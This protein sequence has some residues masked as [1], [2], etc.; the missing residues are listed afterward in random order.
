[1]VLVLE[2]Q[3]RQEDRATGRRLLDGE[4]FVLLGQLLARFVLVEHLLEL[5]G[6]LMLL[7]VQIG[8]LLVQ[9]GYLAACV[10]QGHLVLA[11]HLLALPSQPLLLALSLELLLAPL[12]V[13]HDEALQCPAQLLRPLGLRRLGGRVAVVYR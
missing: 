12:A 8:Q 4:Q 10:I 9:S 5:D 6:Q 13:R 11:L 7:A 1:M 2:A 3:G